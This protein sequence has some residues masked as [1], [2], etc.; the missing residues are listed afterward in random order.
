MPIFPPKNLA[1]NHS[2]KMHLSFNSK[3]SLSDDPE[4][5][6]K[7]KIIDAKSLAL[8]VYLGGLNESIGSFLI[9][10]N[11]QNLETAFRFIKD[12]LDIRYFQNHNKQPHFNYENCSNNTY[13]SKQNTNH[14]LTNYNKPHFDS[15]RRHK[16][17]PNQNYRSNQFHNYNQS[18]RPNNNYSTPRFNNN[19]QFNNNYNE[20]RPFNNNNNQHRQNSTYNS[21]APKEIISQ[22]SD[23]Y[24]PIHLKTEYTRNFVILTKSAFSLNQELN[25]L[26]NNR[27]WSDSNS[28]RGKFLIITYTTEVFEIF[29]MFSKRM[30]MDVIILVPSYHKRHLVYMSN[31]WGNGYHCENSS[32][33]IHSSQ[34]CSQKLKKIVKMPIRNYGGCPLSFN[35]NSI[36]WKMEKNAIDFLMD[37]L[38]IYLNLTMHYGNSTQY[39][40]QVT[41]NA[42]YNR[43]ETTKIIFQIDWTWITA[44]TIRVVHF[45]TISSLFQKEVWLLTGLVFLI[46]VL[47]WW[48]TILLPTATNKFY[49][50][51]NVFIEL[52][53][54]TIHGT[55][56]LIP[57]MHILRY[58]FLIYSFY[59]LIVQT[60]FNTN[61][62]QVLTVPH[63][64]HAIT[65]TK[66]LIQSNMS[67]HV[68]SF[69]HHKVLRSTNSSAIGFRK[70]KKQLRT[71]KNY[72]HSLDLIYN[73]RNAALLMPIVDFFETNEKR[74][75][76]TFTD[77]YILGTVQLVFVLPKGHVLVDSINEIITVLTESGIYK[78]HIEGI[79][80]VSGKN[81]NVDEFVPLSLQHLS[82]VF[83][84]YIV[85]ILLTVF[86]FLLE[87][88]YYWYRNKKLKE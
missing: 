3:I 38:K 63:Y 31:P 70:L 86:V 27:L 9:S 7:Y 11:P 88:I 56:S 58:I 28:P 71:T 19:R 61:L 41:L 76:N 54:L 84:L 10:R 50:F 79:I 36:T 46:T 40:L 65:S 82:F 67:L 29:S 15:N 8:K 20:D 69:V 5:I 13:Q 34:R 74:K 77:N 59:A 66:E 21:F 30:I 23:S 4:I 33:L 24:K 2:G 6:G 55:I 16:F 17:K 45:E 37:A 47:A 60:A 32:T 35:I 72:S 26:K 85:G 64:S 12:E 78:R 18:E 22:I 14:N 73:F 80:Q 57:N 44:A 1:S 68:S 49:Q 48:I 25:H 51:C 75:F 81:T 53:S 43:H 87:C 52:T 39:P 83:A 62:I 42:N